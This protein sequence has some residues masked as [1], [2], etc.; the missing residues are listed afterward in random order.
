MIGAYDVVLTF[1]F[2]YKSNIWPVKM[3]TNGRYILAPTSDGKIFIWNLLTGG[4]SGILSDHGM[5]FKYVVLKHKTNDLLDYGNAVRDVLFHPYKP[6]LF[7]CADDASINIY[8]QAAE[9]MEVED[10]GRRRRTSANKDNNVHVNGNNNN[11]QADTTAP[12]KPKGKVGRPRGSKKDRNNLAASTNSVENDNNNNNNSTTSL[13][14]S[15]ESIAADDV[16]EDTPNLQ[17]NENLE[18]QS[19]IRSAF[20]ASTGA[21]SDA[22]EEKQD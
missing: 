12:K 1:I 11:A 14:A 10:T 7:T 21:E 13:L 4:L 2:S 19:Q 20:R 8:T 17:A 16:M 9:A 3:A 6:L 18:I 22:G 5:N 15:T